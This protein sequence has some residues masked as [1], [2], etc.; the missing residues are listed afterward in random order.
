LKPPG[1]DMVYGS[2]PDTQLTREGYE[3]LGPPTDNGLQEAAK[4]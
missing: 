3:A 1:K 4:P 2:S